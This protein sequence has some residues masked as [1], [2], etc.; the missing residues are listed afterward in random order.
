M[1]EARQ[2]MTVDEARQQIEQLKAEN[3]LEPMQA[4]AKRHQLPLAFVCAIASRET[5]CHN[6][7]GDYRGGVYHGI[8]VMQI[9]I[10]HKIARV[11][12]EGGLWRSQ[13]GL[14]ID[15]GCGILAGGLVAANVHAGLSGDD[16]LRFAAA[17][18]NA[19][20]GA[21]LRGHQAGDVDIYTTGG[22][23][24]CNVVFERMP[25]FAETLA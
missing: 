1:D 11:A 5:N 19:G 13:P 22:S 8:G 6:E 14:L 25:A 21:A 7:L 4:A 15:V 17:A 23:Y 3:C 24:G 9:D 18:Y 16:A 2:Q 12:E 10:Q 20:V